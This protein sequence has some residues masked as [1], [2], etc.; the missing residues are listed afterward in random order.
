M[1]QFKITPLGSELVSGLRRKIDRKTKP[2]G[3]LGRLENLATQI[4]CIQKRL[5]PVLT[6]PT[7]VV[8]AGDHGITA[9]QVSA[10]PRSVTA[11][12]VHSFLGGGAAINVF[13]KQNRLALLVVDAGVDCE[14]SNLEVSAH[15]TFVDAK[16]RCGTRN[17]AVEDALMEKELALCI[18]RGARIVGRLADDGCNAVGLGDMGIGNTSSAALL[19]ST[20]MKIP[21]EQCAGAGSGLSSAGIRHK[22]NVLTQAR[23]RVTGDIGVA[24][25]LCAFGGLEI[26]MLCGALLAAAEK[27]MLIL[28]DGYIV[29]VALRAA[30]GINPS[31]LDYCVFAHRSAEHGHRLLLEHLNAAPL[32]ELEMRLGEGTGAALAFPLAQAAANFLTEMASFEEAGVSD[33]RG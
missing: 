28:I 4:G 16:V 8:F 6:K 29:T 32:L 18:D 33:R 24:R 17:F 12:M 21:V 3:S 19:Q 15:A 5:S 31:V 9:E 25:A 13:A 7:V 23:R 26:A 11:Q 20:L 10:Y 22:I 30:S 14:F 2:V 1:R 27:R